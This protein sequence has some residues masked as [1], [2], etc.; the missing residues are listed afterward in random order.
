MKLESS[1][2]DQ[3]SPLAK[4]PD[5]PDQE[6]SKK[7]HRIVTYIKPDE[8]ESKENM[9]KSVSTDLQEESKTSLSSKPLG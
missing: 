9:Q 7:S 3:Q 8:S 4:T 2:E 1:I 5:T 6:E